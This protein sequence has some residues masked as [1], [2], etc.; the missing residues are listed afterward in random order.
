[1]PST[2]HPDIV[3]SR[4]PV[5][6]REAARHVKLLLDGLAVH[7]QHFAAAV[8][9]YDHLEELLAQGALRATSL[10][11]QR[12]GKARR[13]NMLGWGGIAARDAAMTLYHF[14]T[15]LD[16]IVKGIRKCPTLFARVGE[17]RLRTFQPAFVKN[18]PAATAMRNAV[19]HSSDWGRTPES[20]AFHA[21]KV[22][23]SDDGLEITSGIYLL[24]HQAGRKLIATIRGRLVFVEVTEEW[25]RGL[26]EI[27]RL[28]YD[29]FVPDGDSP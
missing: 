15:T 23:Y 14:E 1:M 16:A 18:F 9:L 19:G 13:R 20:M 26:I 3:L 22:P 25:L 7:V 24:S 27:Q 2:E 5:E 17:A 11:A 21:Y 12:E 8:A 28:V 4:L 6:E 29:A 10:Q